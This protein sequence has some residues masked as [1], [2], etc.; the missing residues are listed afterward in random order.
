MS[1]LSTT[2]STTS[3]IIA[4]LI[5]ALLGLGVVMVFSA[6]ATLDAPLLSPDDLWGSS[7]IRQ[8]I[9]SAAALLAMLLA[10]IV[11]YELWRFRKRSL[12]QPTLL[13]LLLTILLLA[14]T[15]VIGEERNGAKRWLSLGPAGW[16]LS[17]QP[18]EVAKLGSVLFLAAYCGAIGDRIRKFW[19]GLLPALIVLGLIVALVGI[20]DFGTAALIL[21]VGGSVLLAA[22]AKLWHLGLISLPAVFGLVH[23][24]T[25]KSYRMDR[26]LAFLNP[27]AD[28]LGKGY[29]QMQS[30]ITIASGGWWGKGLGWGVQK[31]GYLPEGRSD[32]IFAVI[33][34]ELGTIGGITVIAAFAVLLWQGRRAVAAAPCRFGGLL[35]LGAVLTIGLQAAINI[36]VVTVSAP[37]KGIALPFVSAG[38]TGV[39]FLGILAGMLINVARRRPET[40]LADVPAH[41]QE[42]EE[43]HRMEPPRIACQQSA[44]T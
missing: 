12:W 26:F 24:I 23:L 20:E 11:P 15:L 38:G 36:A 32:F 22:R 25:S 16:G 34:E 7:A 39:L 31:Y 17:F 42:T 21:A 13:F 6:S 28:P 3:T 41:L 33:C 37:T 27:E 18:S 1:L 43:K 4:L 14:A 5:A 35:A 40:D 10:S 8:T 29:H 2:P 9:F 19:F 44:A 30:L